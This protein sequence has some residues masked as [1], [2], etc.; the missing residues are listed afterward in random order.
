MK[1]T[2]R[3]LQEKVTDM[4]SLSIRFEENY[5]N[6]DVQK[7][8]LT[9]SWRTDCTPPKHRRKNVYQRF[10]EAHPRTQASNQEPTEAFTLRRIT[11]KK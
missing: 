10:V 3:D 6:R 8:S 1:I 2:P 4:V 9:H 7:L 5:W 11:K